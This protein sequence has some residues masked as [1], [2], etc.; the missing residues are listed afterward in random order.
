MHD[1]ERHVAGDVAEHDGAVR[2]LGLERRGPRVA[3]VLGVGVAAGER[4]LDQ[5]VDGGSVLGVHHDHGAAFGRGLHGPQDL[6][7]VAVEHAGVGHEQL[8]ATDALVLGE[9]G[10]RL[11]ALLVDAADDL[12]ERVVDGAVAGR[13]VV[14]RL[15]A[16][17]DVLAVALQRHVDDG[18]DATPGGA[19][20]ARLERVAGLG[21]A[22]GQLEV[23]VRID[24]A[25]DHVLARGIHHG[26]RGDCSERRRP[27]ADERH[28]LFA[29]DQD[30]CV[31]TPG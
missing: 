15:Q 31:S 5:H 1:V 17:V 18:R 3:V 23:G 11:Q 26:V 7:V 19:D 8:E 27:G 20:R 21:A 28:D 29:V 14:P 13:L 9:V 10:E 2:G 4:L 30:V 22:E 12:V 16:L 25:R 24:A 6:T